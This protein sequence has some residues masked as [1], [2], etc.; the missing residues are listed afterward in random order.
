[1]SQRLW[2]R[3]LPFLK[4]ALSLVIAVGLMPESRGDITSF[5]ADDLRGTWVF[6]FTVI[7]GNQTGAVYYA[8]VSMGGTASN[9]NATVELLSGGTMQEAPT[10]AV[11]G[12]SMTVTPTGAVSGTITLIDPNAMTSTITFFSGSTLATTATSTNFVLNGVTVRRGLQPNKDT[13]PGDLTSAT[14]PVGAAS[15]DSKINGLATVIT[16]YW[17]ANKISDMEVSGGTNAGQACFLTSAR[18]R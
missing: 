6:T 2:P 10:R 1:M 15:N 9:N 3:L 17:S 8:Q 12:G 4:L 13:I 18:R 16:G 14:P 5:N 7:T 11:T